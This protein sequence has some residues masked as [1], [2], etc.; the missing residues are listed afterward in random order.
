MRSNNLTRSY[1]CSNISFINGNE[2]DGS[3]RGSVFL[4]Y[5]E[6]VLFDNINIFNCTGSGTVF[7][8][9]HSELIQIQDS[10][11][12]N[13]FGGGLGLSNSFDPPKSFIIKNNVVEKSAPSFSTNM[14]EGGKGIYTGGS[15]IFE[16]IYFG[17][18]INTQITENRVKFDPIWG[19][20]FSSAIHVSRHVNLD[21]INTTIG[22]N[23]TE[24]DYAGTAVRVDEGSVVNIY[25]SIFYGDSLYELSLGFSTGS[26]FPAT[27]N[28]LYSNLEGGEDEIQ[29]W[30]NQHTINWLEGNIDTNPQWIETG[31]SAYQLQWNSPCIDAGVPMYEF[32]MDYP[33]IK[34][35]DEKIV[36]YKI[37][38][39][40]LH[41]PSTDLAGNPRIVNGRIDMG[42]YEYQDTSTRIKKLFLKNL[43][44]TKIDVYPT[45]FSEHTF[46]SFKLEE[47]AEVQVIIYDLAGHQVKH[48]MDAKLPTG[49]YSLTWEGKNEWDETTKPGTYIVS[50]II[51]KQKVANTKIVKK[52][53]RF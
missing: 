9:L 3:K 17:R 50:F 32:G 21:L 45:P 39:D 34:I 28:I 16:D 5:N 1:S 52:N 37:D 22:N 51:N 25:N 6:N 15:Y 11:I 10:R 49:E 31:D 38:G 14:L 44:E 2:M 27:T 20:G 33:Y 36:L 8:T 46:I 23:V 19:N 24:D 35:E 13:N 29:N 43:Q 18:I 48:L 47:K 53:I 12:Y 30:Y 42:A 4:N 40:T 41:I 26:D 7:R